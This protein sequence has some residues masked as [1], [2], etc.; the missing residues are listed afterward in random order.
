VPVE[1]QVFQTWKV[2]GGKI[3]T[4]RLFLSEA[5]ALKAVGLEE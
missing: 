2:R 1:M 5:E 4:V 3:V